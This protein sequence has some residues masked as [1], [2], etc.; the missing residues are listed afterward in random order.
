MKAVIDLLGTLPVLTRHVHGAATL[1]EL[2]K[3]GALVQS[4]AAAFVLPLGFRGGAADAATGLYRQPIE[5]LVGV[6][7]AIRNV[8][9]ATGDKAW[10][11]LE[12]LIWDVIQL[13]AGWGP[14]EVFGVF[15]LARGE[16]ISID[17]GTITYQL[18]FA[19][20]DQLRITRP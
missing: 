9:D 5:R 12:P 3:R 8:G 1:G 16:L 10:I 20:E 17:A 4:G 11:E 7:L 18:D 2:T 14:D 6:V 19:I 15:T 13:L